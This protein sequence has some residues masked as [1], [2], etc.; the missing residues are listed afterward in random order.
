MCSDIYIVDAA[1]P[2]WLGVLFLLLI[3]LT[4][5]TVGTAYCME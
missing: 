3:W 4:F 1:G 5:Q 2:S